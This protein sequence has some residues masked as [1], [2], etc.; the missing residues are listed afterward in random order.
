MTWGKTSLSTVTVSPATNIMKTE[1]T[2]PSNAPSAPTRYSGQASGLLIPSSWRISWSQGTPGHYHH[3]KNKQRPMALQHTHACPPCCIALCL[4]LRYSPGWM[5]RWGVAHSLNPPS[6][7]RAQHLALSLRQQ[8]TSSHN[9][10]CLHD[11]LGCDLPHT[12]QHC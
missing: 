12:H 7:L 9:P 3:N 5:L 2:S 4:P 10:H 6:D 1:A 8:S 11:M